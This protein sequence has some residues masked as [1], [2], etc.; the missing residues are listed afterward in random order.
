MALMCATGCSK[1]TPPDA[2]T[3]PTVGV[4]PLLPIM[5]LIVAAI[6]AASGWVAVMM[7]QSL[8]RR[9]NLELETQRARSRAV[10]EISASLA[11]LERAFSAW[12]DPFAGYAG[13][14]P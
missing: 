4:E 10:P 13:M 1:Q 9:N 5:P 14:V 3:V 7:G 12:L 8:G 11:R 2:R 6:A